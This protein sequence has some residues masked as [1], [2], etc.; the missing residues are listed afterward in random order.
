MNPAPPIGERPKVGAVPETPFTPEILK[1]LQMEPGANPVVRAVMSQLRERNRQGVTYGSP[2]EFAEAVAPGKFLRP[3][4]IEYLNA[5]L[6]KLR[7]GNQRLLV[8]MPP[9]HG[10]SELIS[11][12]TPA[13]FLNEFP[14]KRVILASYE[15]DFAANWGRR[16][17]NLIQEHVADLR[18]RVSNDSAAANRWTTTANGAM[19]TAGAGGPVTGRGGELIIID[20]PVKNAEEAQSSARRAAIM[21]WFNSTLYTRLEPGGSLIVVMTRWHQDDLVGRLLLEMEQ[22]G[23]QWDVIK[24]PAIAET[25]D[26]LGRV[27]GEALWPERY[28]ESALERIKTRNLYWWSALYQQTPILS[29]G[30]FFNRQ[31]FEVVE[32]VPAGLAWVRFWDM[33]ATDPKRGGDPDY[34]AGALCSIDSEGSVWVKD[35][36]HFRGGP[37]DVERVITQTA[38]LDG[39]HT[40]IYFEEEPGSAGKALIDNYKRTILRDF[41][42]KVL[43]S[44]SRGSKVAL[45]TPL[46]AQAD[47]GNVKL[48]NRHWVKPFLDECEAFPYGTHDDMVDAVS[49]AYYVL[50][51]S[52]WRGQSKRGR[53]S[54]GYLDALE[55][56]MVECDCGQMVYAAYDKNCPFCGR[57]LSA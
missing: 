36:V 25:A 40:E 45:A 16:V 56:Q 8:M 5:A 31:N 15:A 2:A 10:K 38:K 17:R 1:Q 57:M 26:E 47:A 53:I 30:S 23:E 13:W 44:G 21:E 42:V 43:R 34:L 20:D 50:T 14:E 19:F 6:A 52:A 18:V 7:E 28:D 22:G 12:Y 51:G 49:S 27:P 41:T 37:A 48:L 32:A 11:Y 33:A 24:F 9:R 4:H 54:A 3:P 35:I 39:N 29:E 55:S 46:A